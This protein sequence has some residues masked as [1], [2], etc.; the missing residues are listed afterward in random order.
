[1][2]IGGDYLDFRTFDKRAGDRTDRLIQGNVDFTYWLGEIVQSL[3]VG[4]GVYAGAGGQTDATWD[5]ATMPLP[6]NG[7][8]YGYADVELGGHLEHVPASVG[9]QVIAG[10]GKT[11]FG[12]GVEGRMRLGARTATNILFST[13]S[14]DQVGFL[15]EVRFGTWPL[16][17]QLGLGISVGATNQPA[18]GEVAVKLGTELELPIQ[19]NVSLLVRGSWQGRSVEH[20]GAGGGAG[21]GF[22]W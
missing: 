6:H 15:S 12:M 21:L 7:F 8:Q 10:V 2:H 14:V 13:R 19:R 17:K 5:P 16:A 18:R 4:Y 20:S 22:S 11:G 9:G 3:G 1:V